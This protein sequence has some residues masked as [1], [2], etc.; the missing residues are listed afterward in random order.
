MK[1]S[2]LAFP[3]QLPIPGTHRREM[4]FTASD[5]WDIQ[6]SAEGVFRLESGPLLF[7]TD[8]IA[9]WVPLVEAAAEPEPPHIPSEP[10]PPLP[11]EPKTGTRKRGRS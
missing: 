11:L 2:H 4:V 6:Q 1:L 5:G 10:V 8:G 7:W 3:W 9:T